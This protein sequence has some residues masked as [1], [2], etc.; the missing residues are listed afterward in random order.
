MTD[1]PVD[2]PSVGNT[3]TDLTLPRMD[4]APEAGD[5]ISDLMASLRGARQMSTFHRLAVG[6]ML[7]FKAAGILWNHRRTW[8]LVIL[9]A[10]I[11][12]AVFVLL[13]IFMVSYAGDIIGWVWSKPTGL[14]ALIFW[15]AAIVFA[16][17]LSLVASY[18]FTLILA[19]IVASPFNDVLSA[20]VEREALAGEMP[21]PEYGLIWGSLRAVGSSIV[22]LLSYGIVMLPI[23]VLNLVPVVGQ[24]A[25]S[26]LSTGVSA[27]FIALEFTDYSLERR[28]LNLRQK[29][30]LLEDNRTFALGF[31]LGTAALIWVPLLN[32]L[33][34]PIAVAGG[35]LL[36]II[37][38][39]PAPSIATDTPLERHG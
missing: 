18:A 12:A 29:F 2:T 35:T 8:P 23:L 30:E 7:P 26:I 17:A 38:T 19:G 10:L 36:G 31:G 9:P 4:D 11:N 32:F 21:E 33:T 16:S 14:I 24:V 20:R 22:I 15:W 37:L 13:A 1:S 28:G 25:A 6:M 39:E 27:M 34:I 5:D 3:S